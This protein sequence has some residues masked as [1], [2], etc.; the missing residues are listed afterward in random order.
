MDERGGIN[1]SKSKLRKVYLKKSITDYI[2]C[3]TGHVILC[4]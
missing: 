2:R 3:F 1:K 4:I